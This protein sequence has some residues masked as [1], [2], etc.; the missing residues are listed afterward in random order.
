EGG[1][2]LRDVLRNASANAQ[3][4]AAAP[5]PAAQQQNLTSLTDEIA[6]SMDQS[7]LGE[8]WRRYQ[9]G[10]QAV[11]SRRIYTLSGQGT[12]DDVRKRIQRDAEFARTAQTYMSEFEQLLQQASQG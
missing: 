5:A 4:A 6:R 7:A 3:G 8:A 12:Y 9:A 11:F 10:E 2:W 1:G